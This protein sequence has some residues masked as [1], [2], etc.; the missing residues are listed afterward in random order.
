MKTIPVIFL[1]MASSESGALRD[2]L[3]ERSAI[4]KSLEKAVVDGQCIVL[5]A[6]VKSVEDIFQVFR[7]YPQKISVFH[8]AGHGSED[9]LLL[10]LE[11][12]NARGLSTSALTT[13]LSD[14]YIKLVFLNCCSSQSHVEALLGAG[15]PVVIATSSEVHDDI[16]CDFA[17]KFYEGL[18]NGHTVKR[19]FDLSKSELMTRADLSA[20]PLRGPVLGTRAVG[21]H[22][23]LW[24]LYTNNLVRNAELWKLEPNKDAQPRS[25]QRTPASIRR[26]LALFST[27]LLLLGAFFAL[28]QFSSRPSVSSGSSGSEVTAPNSDAPN[29][30]VTVLNVNQPN[31]VTQ[32]RCENESEAVNIPD[33]NLKTVLQETLGIADRPLTC[34]DLLTLT[35]LEAGAKGIENLEGLQYATNL[36]SLQLEENKISDISAL[37]TLTKLEGLTLWK[38]SLTSLEP[39]AKLENLEWLYIGQM[40][41]ADV[42]PLY[43]LSKLEVLHMNRTGVSDLS[44]LLPSRYPNLRELEVKGNGISDIT[45]LQALGKLE[46]LSLDNNKITDLTPLVENAGLAA[47][48]VVSLEQNP[49]DTAQGSDDQQALARLASRGVEV[50][51]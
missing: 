49:L 30:D 12:E 23:E 36:K 29:S 11:K 39:L 22:A 26:W 40:P 24:N 42:S 37:S 44:F 28:R 2:V 15:A 32:S 13:L 9:A 27:S 5:E 8:Y 46:N 31:S 38:N 47:G 18:A 20:A 48:D 45:P 19:A 25:P 43:S 1:A 4:R 33:L 10:Y 34:I 50:H 35:K 21:E 3:R 41:L 17:Q 51:Y 7:S 6:E 14:P 16:A